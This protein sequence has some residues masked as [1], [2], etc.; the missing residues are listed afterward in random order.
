MSEPPEDLELIPRAVRDKL[1]RVRIKLHLSDWQRLS[2]AER[3]RLVDQPCATAEE[4]ERY[5]REVD[6][7]IRD[8]TGRPPDRLG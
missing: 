8:R 3:H 7:L 4:V 1:D 5:G 6:R 2:V